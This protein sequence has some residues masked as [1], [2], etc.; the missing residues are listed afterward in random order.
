MHPNALFTSNTRPG[1][2]NPQKDNH[3]VT[4][5]PSLCRTLDRT[6]A[7]KTRTQPVRRLTF[8]C[9]VM[10]PYSFYPLTR[11]HKS[12]SH[13]PSHDSSGAHVAP[14]RSNSPPPV[15]PTSPEEPTIK[16]KRKRADAAQL[17][18]LNE[19]YSRTAFPS[20]EE[21]IAL[22]RMLDMSARSVQIWC[23]SYPPILLRL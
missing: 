14:P 1:L 15:T 10:H 3:L 17:K 22:A 9:S 12:S 20:T 18:V 16:K 4:V 8:R 19:T 13:V 2:E 5:G 23:A 11:S 21:R 6:V 7:K